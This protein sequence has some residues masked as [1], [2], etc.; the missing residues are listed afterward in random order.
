MLEADRLRQSLRCASHIRRELLENEKELVPLKWFDYR[1]DTPLDA[2]VKFAEAYALVYKDKWAESFDRDEAKRKRAIVAGG[3]TNN[4]RELS[5]FWR[6]RQI[7]DLIGV[8]YDSFVRAAMTW[9]LRSQWKR[10]PRPNQLV[11][12]VKG[13]SVV[14]HV[15]A[16]WAASGESFRYSRLPQYREENFVGLPAQL[17]HREH[18]IQQINDRVRPVELIGRMV[19][20]E[21][22]LSH[23]LAISSFGYDIVEEAK[24]DFCRTTEP[25]VKLSTA[26]FRPACYMVPYAFDESSSMC[27]DC[28]IKQRCKAA[29]RATDK[30]I[31]SRHGSLDPVTARERQLNRERVARYRAKKR[32]SS[33]SMSV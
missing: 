4:R 28:Q 27:A 17:A 23:D 32:G 8:Q 29:A 1:F 25:V 20:G 3:I 26:Q 19:F 31:A 13:Q 18:V 12:E 9:H 6:V 30:H 33:V 24:R 16:S 7:A 11:C 5:S 2:T 10:L 14:E 21:R 15:R 22:V